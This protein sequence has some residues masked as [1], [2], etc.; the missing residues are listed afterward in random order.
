M[1][2]ILIIGGGIVGTAV[3]FF[4]AEAGGA[5][6]TVVERDPTYARASTALSA[7]GLRQQFSTPLNIALSC[8]GAEF[9]R[10]FPE[11]LHFRENGYL[12]LAATEAQEARMRHAHAIQRE[13]GAEVALL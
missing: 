13:A 3:A 6:I 11:D 5:E 4:L 8:F 10:G 7:S 12:F 2:R 9:L 1:Q